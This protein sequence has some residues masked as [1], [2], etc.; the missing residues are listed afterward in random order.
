MIKSEIN[1]ILYK[2]WYYYI[3]PK[4]SIVDLINLGNTNQILY[5]YI[6]ESSKTI[7][8]NIDETIISMYNISY[9]FLKNE[10]YYDF[11]N[12]IDYQLSQIKNCNLYIRGKFVILNNKIYIIDNCIIKIDIIEVNHSIYIE[13]KKIITSILDSRI[14]IKYRVFDIKENIIKKGVINI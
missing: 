6:S 1:N 14:K 12:K 3:F 13:C 8:N 2:I 5:L 10:P 4:I 11:L 7:L 9:D